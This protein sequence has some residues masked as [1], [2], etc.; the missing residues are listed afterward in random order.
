MAVSDVVVT[1]LQ[2][3]VEIFLLVGHVEYGIGGGDPRKIHL[4]SRELCRAALDT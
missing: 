4:A 1:E 3:T 2:Q